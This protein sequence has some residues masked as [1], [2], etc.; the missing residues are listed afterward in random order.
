MSS[1]D[2]GSHQLHADRLR[3]RVADSGLTDRDLRLGAL[4]RGAGGSGIPDP[5]DSLARQIGED[6]SRVTDAQVEAVR[7]AT[8]SEKAA[9]EIILTAAIG[10][11]LRRWDAAARAIEEARDAAS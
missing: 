5:Y 7:A 1:D 10:A 2:L 8:G 6:S 3:G 9:F 4:A 11:G